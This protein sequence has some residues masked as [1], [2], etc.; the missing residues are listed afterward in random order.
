M[1]AGTGRQRVIYD[2]NEPEKESFNNNQR[3]ENLHD[4]EDGITIETQM[5]DSNDFQRMDKE[6]K[7]PKTKIISTKLSTVF[8]VPHGNFND[9]F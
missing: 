7:M 9:S 3:E 6:L 4:D 2:D 5:T 1:T 8:E